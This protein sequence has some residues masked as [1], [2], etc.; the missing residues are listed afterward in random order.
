MR[1]ADCEQEAGKRWISKAAEVVASHQVTLLGDD[2]SSKQP[3]CA[4]ALPQGLHFILTYKP[5]SHATR[6]EWLACWQ[7]NDGIAALAR[8]HW[9]GRFTDVRLYRLPQ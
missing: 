5:D 7:A 9:Y 3:F 6:S 4:L 2:L 1:I 8:H